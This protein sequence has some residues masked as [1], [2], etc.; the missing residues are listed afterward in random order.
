[1]LSAS[2]ALA[3]QLASPFVLA[4]V[5]WQVAVGLVARL[6]PRLQI[7]FAALPGQLLTGLVLLGALSGAIASAWLAGVRDGFASLP[8]GV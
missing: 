2:F 3:F 4:S 1:M 7:Y 5:L 6:V 8:G